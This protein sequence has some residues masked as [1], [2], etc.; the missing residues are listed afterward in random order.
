MVDVN[1]PPKE[2]KEP[3]LRKRDTTSTHDVNAIIAAHKRQR[4]IDA[5][6]I[7]DFEGRIVESRKSRHSLCFRQKV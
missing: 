2:P 1:K 6:E 4:E 5:D 3:R 7:K